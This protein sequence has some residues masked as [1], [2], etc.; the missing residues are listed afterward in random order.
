MHY[1]LCM[2]PSELRAW[3]DRAHGGNVTAAAIVLGLTR[4]AVGYYLAG[5][6][7]IPL[8]VAKLVAALAV[9]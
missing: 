8:I 5:Q 3:I 1:V 4:R 9:R 7:P 6:R 2:T